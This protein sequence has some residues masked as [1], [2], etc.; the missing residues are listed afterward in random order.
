MERLHVD[1]EGNLVLKMANCNQVLQ[2]RPLAYQEVDGH[3]RVVEARYVVHGREV[4]LKLGDYQRDR[5]LVIDP[6]LAYVT[7]FGGS[8]F[9]DGAAMAADSAGN[10][11]IAGMS[12]GPYYPGAHKL[13][14]FDPADP[15]DDPT[16]VAKFDVSGSLTYITYIAGSLGARA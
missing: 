7:Y 11:Y 4:A 13:G 6:E 1:D 12:R 2:R 3:R 9:E 15:Y 16:Y 10:V 14:P 5:S 8:R